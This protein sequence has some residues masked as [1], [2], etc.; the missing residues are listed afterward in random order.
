MTNK[1]YV[2]VLRRPDKEDPLC[3]GKGQ[4]FYVGK[5]TG[6]RIEAH[7]WE[8]ASL[9]HKPGRK[10]YKINIIHYLWKNGLKF[11]REVLAKELTEQEAFDLEINLI[12]TYG[13]INKKN[14]C[15]A[16][17]TEGG[18][19]AS[20]RIVSIEARQKASKSNTGKVRSIETRKKLSDNKKGEKHPYYGQH[21]PEETRKKISEANK[22][23]KKSP[24]HIFKMAQS[25]KERFK[26]KT[27]HPNFGK[28]H[29]EETRK[30]ISESH[31][32]TKLSNEHRKKISE[33]MRGNA[34]TK[35]RPA[36]NKG[37]RHT[38]ESLRKMREAH[39]NR[40]EVSEETRKKL[41]EAQKRRPR[42]TE[43][44]RKKISDALKGKPH[45]AEHHRKVVESK[46]RNVEI[47]NRKLEAK[48]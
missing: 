31:K 13:C 46:R 19:G 44:T 21:L 38:E 33:G 6:R 34:N 43:E 39:K 26:D 17:L 11:K 42:K 41:S 16:N 2:Y 28:H 35:G 7:K 23:K 15:L 47:N 45:S 1:F 14:G 12:L 48:W 24:E 4:P 20:G 10:S 9:L 30:K 8:A 40:G 37:S 3:P 25:L 27:K 5:G 32:G 22:G 18:D 29:S 36:H